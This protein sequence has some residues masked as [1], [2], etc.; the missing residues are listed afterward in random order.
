MRTPKALANF[1]P[2]FEFARTLGANQDNIRTLKALAK[3]PN[4]LANAFSVHL[5][6]V[7]G[8]P[9]LKQPW[10]DIRQR[11]R[12]LSKSTAAVFK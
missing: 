7:V 12:R 11:L 10:A 9:G 2:G 5:V 1:S 6:L 4:H 8:H 3:Q